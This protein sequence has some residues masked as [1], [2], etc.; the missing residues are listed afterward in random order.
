MIELHKPQPSSSVGQHY[1][2]SETAAILG[3]KTGTLRKWRLRGV[4]P[5][6][7][8]LGRAVRYSERDLRVWL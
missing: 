8:K 7:R 1:R 6:F 2:D 4:G 3:I 5:R